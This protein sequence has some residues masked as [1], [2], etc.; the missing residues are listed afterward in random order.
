MCL[1]SGTW[2]VTIVTFPTRVTLGARGLTLAA[3]AVDTKAFDLLCGRLCCLCTSPAVDLMLEVRLISRDVGSCLVVVVCFLSQ[4]SAS[5][6]GFDLVRFF[7]DELFHVILLINI[8]GETGVSQLSYERKLATVKVNQFTFLYNQLSMSELL[9]RSILVFIQVESDCN[10]VFIL[11]VSL[12]ALLESCRLQKDM[13]GYASRNADKGCSEL[14]MCPEVCV[15]LLL[16]T[17]WARRIWLRAKADVE[18]GLSC[19]AMYECWRLVWS[20]AHDC[21]SC[22]SMLLLA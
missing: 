20:A 4:R 13:C 15:Y 11:L 12:V 3:L 2:H 9:G 10:V 21:W 6:T 8:D 19:A 5:K 22:T 18:M 14:D 7:R 17:D 16:V 1:R